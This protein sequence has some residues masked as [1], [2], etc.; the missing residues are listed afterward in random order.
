MKKNKYL[1]TFS[2]SLLLVF[3][4]T[5][6]AGA[7]S[8]ST[9]NIESIDSYY[10]SPAINKHQTTYNLDFTGYGGIQNNGVDFDYLNQHLNESDKNDILSN[11][12][13]DGLILMG[14]GFQGGK[15]NYKNFNISAGLNEKG[16]IGISE[17]IIEVILKGNKLGQEYKFNDTRG[18]LAVYSDI[19][20]GYS[21]SLPQLKNKL[22]AEKVQI[23][24]T[25]HYLSGGFAK[26]KGEGSFNLNYEDT[27][28]GDGKVRAEYAETG[29][30]YSFDLGLGVQRNDQLSWST[31]LLN[32]GSIK[33]EDPRY[34]EYEYDPETDSFEETTDKPLSELKYNLPLTWKS[35]A[36]YN[37]KKNTKL[38][39]SYSLSSYDSGY[40]DHQ[41][42][43]G[44]K[45][46][47][48]KFLPLKGGVT[49]SSLQGGLIFSAGV[50]LKL[51]IFKTD[52]GFSDIRALFEKGKNMSVSVNT[53]FSF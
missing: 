2:L 38:F 9:V 13:N 25:F 26:I 29:T 3:L 46:N 41:L 11:L 43:A 15:F 4:I 22:K 30:G 20:V 32:I 53:G 19:G 34:Y 40:N 27:I 16:V 33:G 28:S 37:W 35:G 12:G 10:A 51:G 50:S 47:K 18:D 7:G 17:D 14:T 42:A 23:G 36:K 31:S 6:A 5:I 8:S 44:V 48:F 49:Y 24:G 39:G 1:Y 52:I 45:Y 21:R